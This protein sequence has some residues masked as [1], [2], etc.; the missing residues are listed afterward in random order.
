MRLISRILLFAVACLALSATPGRAETG[1]PD[2]PV[3]IV[4][5]YPPGGLTDIL[6][7]ALAEK[8][9]EKWGQQVITV[10]M[11]GANG[12]VA[13]TNVIGARP[14][15]YRILFGTDATLAT[16]PALYS[17]VKYDVSKDLVP[18][19]AIGSYQLMLVINK[20]V[21]A[22]T[23][24]EFIDYAKAQE[25]PLDYASVGIGSAH[26][27][28]MELLK[29]SAGIKMSHIPYQGGAPATLAHVSGEVQAMFN[30]PAPIKGYL[31]TGELTALAVSGDTRSTLYPDLPTVAE[32]G[33]PEFNVVNWYG[34]LAPVGTP[35]D[36]IK[37]IETSI[38]EVL[39][40]KSFQDWMAGQGIAPLS[41]NS[42]EFKS[43]IASESQRLASFLTRF[44]IKAE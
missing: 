43:F 27:L 28:A 15:G 41:K 13:T 35:P 21:P 38:A 14:D 4:V 6:T 39:A 29:N 31:E 40:D 7:R 12:I 20:D 23:F 25:P 42:E 5:P 37:K 11:P 1:Y 2:R 26:H 17:D 24:K 8:L 32:L 34:L 36:V 3:E 22:K 10:N 30:G 16:N 9:T 18:I 19:A 33:Y 44:G